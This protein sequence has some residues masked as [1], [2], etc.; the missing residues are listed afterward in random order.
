MAQYAGHSTDHGN[1]LTVSVL[2]S[3]T[4]KPVME[5]LYR[6]PFTVLEVSR[7]SIFLITVN[8]GNC[9]RGVL[10]AVQATIK[11]PSCYRIW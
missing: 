11:G 2:L 8:W 10:A 7:S 6:V 9:Q 1:A 4:P 3:R 5:L